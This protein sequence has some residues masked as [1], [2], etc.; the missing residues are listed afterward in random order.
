MAAS[1][2]HSEYLELLPESEAQ[3]IVSIVPSRLFVGIALQLV[4]AL[5]AKPRVEGRHRYHRTMDYRMSTTLDLREITTRR[6]RRRDFSL[7]LSVKIDHLERTHW[8]A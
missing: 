8:A 6:H 2:P 5:R 3:V 1:T 7:G 4:I